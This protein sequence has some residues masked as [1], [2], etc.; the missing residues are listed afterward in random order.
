MD[1]AERLLRRYRW[2][3]DDPRL[4]NLDYPLYYTDWILDEVEGTGLDP[5]LV[6]ALMKQESAFAPH[7]R[8]YV[9][10][11]GLMQLMP[12]TAEEWARRLRMGSV[13]EEDLYE[14][15][16]NI[17][18]GIPYLAHLVERFGS[19][20]KALAAYNGGPTNVRRWERRVEDERPETFVESIGYPETRTYVR[21]ILNNYHR[22]RYLWGQL[23]DR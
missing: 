2:D 12:A 4:R 3:E 23:S 11:R 9:G 7:A 18:L 6:L 20:E 13:G 10:A 19:S 16:L 22:Y 5:F 14:P 1:L 8:S 21:T 15:R 17:R